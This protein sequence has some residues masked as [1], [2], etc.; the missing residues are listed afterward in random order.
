MI[1]ET[2]ELKKPV[3]LGDETITKLEF[4]ELLAKDLRS[5]SAKPTFDDFLNLVSKST[6][7]GKS[8]IDRLSISDATKAVAVVSSFFDDGQETGE[9][10]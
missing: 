2:I 8:M 7:V 9:A 5:I 4:R 10:S 6:L 1:V 3:T